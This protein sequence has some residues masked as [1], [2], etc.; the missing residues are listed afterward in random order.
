MKKTID[1]Q[2]YKRKYRIESVIGQLYPLPDKGRYRKPISG[3]PSSLVVDVETQRYYWNSHGEEG[4][5]FDWLQNRY[6]FDIIAAVK[7]LDKEIDASNLSLPPKADVKPKKFNVPI[8]YI[9]NCRNLLRESS[10]AVSFLKER[11]ITVDLATLFSIGFDPKRNAIVIPYFDDKG[12]LVAVNVRYLEGELRYKA[13]TGSRFT[14]YTKPGQPSP[15]DKLLYVEGEFK[16]V[17]VYGALSR[18]GDGIRAMW[19]VGSSS[20][21]HFRAEWVKGIKTIVMIPDPDK[22]GL[23]FAQSVK[24]RVNNGASVKIYVPPQKIDD[25]IAVDQSTAEKWLLAILARNM[26]DEEVVSAFT[27]CW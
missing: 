10:A 18:L 20:A 5:V 7:W 16:A 6:G 8:S 26:S 17:S 19:K 9:E 14:L 25:W 21:P 1:F 12:V 13:I 4:D 2:E 24:K 3:E 11:G 23:N 27:G 22:A 15:S